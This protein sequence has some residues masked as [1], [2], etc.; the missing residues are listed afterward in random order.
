VLRSGWT[1]ESP[2]T[3]ADSA[4]PAE[5]AFTYDGRG[6]ILTT[7]Y[8]S[9]ANLQ[10]TT[11]ASY[12]GADRLDT[13]VPAGGTASSTFTDA[14]GRT[15]ASWSYT[16]ATPTG[17]AADARVISYTYFP[18]GKPHTITGPGGQQ[19]S[20]TYDLHGNQLT[21]SD[22]DAGNSSMAGQRS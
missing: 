16:T 1:R 19:W 12:P 2:C 22:P 8:Y 13:T 9:K 14:L 17:N 21:M 7:G 15:T 3:T 5:S 11:S 18:N 4:V 20:Y 10:W 6:R